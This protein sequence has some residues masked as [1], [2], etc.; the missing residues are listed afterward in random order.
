M[1]EIVRH[2]EKAKRPGVSEW[3]KPWT[4]GQRR[5]AAAIGDNPNQND[6]NQRMA[7]HVE[8]AEFE[9]GADESGS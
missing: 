4:P 9:H 5:L 8:L 3:R 1:R 7:D 2:Q 6:H